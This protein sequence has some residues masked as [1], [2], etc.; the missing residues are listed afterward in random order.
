M[1][2]VLNDQSSLPDDVIDVV[3]YSKPVISKW[4]R[5][6]WVDPH[7]G[8]IESVVL[9]SFEEIRHSICVPENAVNVRR[10]SSPEAADR[11]RVVCL[12]SISTLTE[13]IVT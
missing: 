5:V 2:L 4:P 11:L 3:R 7:G 6:A 12:D 8:V 10:N 1:C 9:I 13:A